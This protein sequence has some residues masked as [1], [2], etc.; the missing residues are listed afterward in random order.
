MFFFGCGKVLESS[1][2]F[3]FFGKDFEQ[4]LNLNSFSNI[5]LLNLSIFYFTK[6]FKIAQPN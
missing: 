2:R 4:I 6:Y 1:I 5:N 3:F